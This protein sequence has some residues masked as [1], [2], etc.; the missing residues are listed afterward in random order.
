MS[1]R[2]KTANATSVAGKLALY[3]DAA[4]EEGADHAVVMETAKVITAP[5]VRLKCRF[6]CGGYG[7]CLCCPP[8]SPTPEEMRRVLDSYEHAILLHRHVKKGRHPVDEFNEVTVDLEKRL[9]L[10]GYYKAW[11]TGS[12]PCERCATCDTSGACRHPDRA[13]PSMEACGIDVFAT[14]RG[15]GLPIEVKTTRR[16]ERD[17]YTLIL[18]E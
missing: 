5:W 4:L 3:V 16:E 11:A 17:F 14:A 8:F 6:G 10:D 1:Q 12:G 18:V 7:G 13:R 15:L 2:T 9:F